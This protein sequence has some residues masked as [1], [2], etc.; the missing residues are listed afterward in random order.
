MNFNKFRT[1]YLHKCI[2]I[3]T[4]IITGNVADSFHTSILSTRSILTLDAF[5]RMQLFLQ[6]CFPHLSKRIMCG[7]IFQGNAITAK[8]IG[9]FVTTI[10]EWLIIS[11]IVGRRRNKKTSQLG[12]FIQLCFAICAMRNKWTELWGWYARR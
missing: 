12:F 6:L 11:S 2:K 5:H 3:R 8:L 9:T 1:F 4:R 10:L 7:N